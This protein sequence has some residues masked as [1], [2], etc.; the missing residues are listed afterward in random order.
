MS[1]AEVKATVH[2][3]SGTHSATI[4]CSDDL[5]AEDLGRVAASA[6]RLARESG[7]DPTTCV[8]CMTFR[9]V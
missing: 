4:G 9:K 8:L 6:V 3:P 7:E 2:S 1:R 5:C